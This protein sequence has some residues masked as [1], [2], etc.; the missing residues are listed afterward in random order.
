MP[1][2]P[3]SCAAAAVMQVRGPVQKRHPGCC[4]HGTHWV[5]PVHGFAAGMEPDAL[6]ATATTGGS[7]GVGDATRGTRASLIEGATGVR[8]SAQASNTRSAI[9]RAE[10]RAFPPASAGF[11]GREAMFSPVDASD[12]ATRAS[13][14]SRNGPTS[15]TG[16]SMFGRGGFFSLS[17]MVVSR[18]D[19]GVKQ[20]GAQVRETVTGSKRRDAGSRQTDTGLKPTDAG[21][22]QTRPALSLRTARVERR[23]AGM[24]RRSAVPV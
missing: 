23:T 14:F 7:S 22:T 4:V 20:G 3:G 13:F 15:S 9:T 1:H 21:T 16:A 24:R 6:G 8:F 12:S 2:A 18:T 10:R 5:G 17:D 11:K 19:G